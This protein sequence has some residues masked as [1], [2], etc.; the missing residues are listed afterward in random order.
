[1]KFYVELKLNRKEDS[2]DLTKAFLSHLGVEGNLRVNEMKAYLEIISKEIPTELFDAITD[3]GTIRKIRY[4]NE[5]SEKQKEKNDSKHTVL[6]KP[7][8]AKKEETVSIPQLEEIAKKATSFE[9]FAEL[10]A[11]WLE[12]GKKTEYF[13][14]LV[15]ATAEV[16]EITWKNLE[17]VLDRKEVVHR[18]SDK[19]WATKRV[20]EKLQEESIKIMQLLNAIGE[21]KEYS[22]GETTSPKPRVKLE[23]MPEIPSFEEV[24]A[25]V[26]KTRPVEERVL[27]VLDSMGLEEIDSEKKEFCI[28]IANTAVRKKEIVAD[29]I[30]E[31]ANIPVVDRG[32]AE[33]SFSEFL[34]NFV[35]KYDS[36]K[37]VKVFAFLSE[38]QKVIMLD[39]ELN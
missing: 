8:E 4:E 32:I 7:K 6:S 26:D 27:Y 11:E 2:K 30:L 17:N 3:V 12:M 21:Y 22:F 13:K 35:K 18:T 1:M 24:L 16:D 36:E 38:L 33:M 29:A 25:S 10:I 19:L 39:T 37:K 9:N 28:K 20:A 15:I 5:V 14:N 23:C 31:E 34:N